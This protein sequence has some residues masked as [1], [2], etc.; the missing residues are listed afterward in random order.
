VAI[1][2]KLTGDDM[3]D[4]ACIT[5]EMY[6]IKDIDQLKQLLSI[7]SS[8]SENLINRNRFETIE[9]A[10]NGYGSP[11]RRMYE[12]IKSRIY[13]GDYERIESGLNELEQMVSE[14]YP[15]TDDVSYF[16]FS[17]AFEYYLYLIKFGS[18]HP[19]IRLIPEKVFTYYFN[20]GQLLLSAGRHDLAQI[21]FSKA[22]K[23]NPLSVKALLDTADLF[24]KFGE[25][26]E[27]YSLTLKALEYSFFKEDFAK[28]YRNLGHHFMSKNKYSLAIACYVISNIYH[29]NDK[30]SAE[31]LFISQKMNQVIYNPSI[32]QIEKIFDEN[33][34]PF[35]P[36]DDVIRLS[37]FMGQK[38]QQDS[39][40]E[41]ASYFYEICYGLTQDEKVKRI[42]DELR[43]G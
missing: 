33:N 22:L 43:N 3:I 35:G 1:R 23:I 19:I 2:E 29:Y 27:Y 10:V 30:A 37:Y 18:D 38:M 34:I 8:I 13:R 14:T 25:T 31:L 39:D 7:V 11:I 32:E 26:D 6:R 42:L 20:L 5:G 16:N 21:A 24:E 12:E 4:F 41:A 15:N 28:G 9:D 36:D 40:Y 17:H